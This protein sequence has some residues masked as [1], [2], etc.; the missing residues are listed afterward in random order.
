MGGGAEWSGGRE[1]VLD[2]AAV[3][4]KTAGR[5]MTGR[6]RHAKCAGVSPSLVKSRKS[7]VVNSETS[8]LTF[9]YTNLKF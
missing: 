1:D 4:S 9:K 7:Y 8:R 6:G 2:E 5:V 3:E